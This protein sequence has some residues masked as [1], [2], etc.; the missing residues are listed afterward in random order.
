MRCA[1]CLDLSQFFLFKC[2]RSRILGVLSTYIYRY[3]FKNLYAIL[4]CLFFVLNIK[5]SR[6]AVSHGGWITRNPTYPGWYR[7]YY[8]TSIFDLP[9]DVLHLPYPINVQ[10][11]DVQLADVAAR[12]EINAAPES[13]VNAALAMIQQKK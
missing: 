9:D 12:A 13:A 3:A 10:P 8:P 2:V 6:A 7:V 11:K 5:L 1:N 4:T